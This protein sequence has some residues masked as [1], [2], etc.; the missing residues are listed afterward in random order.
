MLLRL[1]P[2][3][4]FAPKLSQETAQRVRVA[5]A[6]AEEALIRTHVAN[7]LHFIELLDPELGF[8]RAI[9]LY[10]RELM[11]PE[12]LGAVVMNRTL[13]TLSQPTSPGTADD[14]D[15]GATSV[16]AAPLS[17]IHLSDIRLS[18]SRRRRA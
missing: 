2:E 11:L 17:D 7:A 13:V 18:N 8:E 12:A 10:V 5:Q 9:D 3:T 16:P 6:L 14:H 4:L 1:L 15:S